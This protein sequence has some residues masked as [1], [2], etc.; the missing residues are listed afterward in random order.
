MLF[1]LQALF[2]LFMLTCDVRITGTVHV[3]HIAGA[4]HVVHVD[5]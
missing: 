2:M 3:V 5:M 1:I 4:V